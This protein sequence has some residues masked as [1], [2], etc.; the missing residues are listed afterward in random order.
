MK[1][2]VICPDGGADW[3]VSEL[4][5]KTPMEAG[6]L[7]NLGQLA[8]EGT[9]GRALHIPPGMDNGSDICCM[10]LLGFD[11]AKH[12]TGR[13]PLEAISLG[14]NL[15]PEDIAVRC[16]TVCIEDGIMV[17][18]TA[19]HITTA[20]SKQL[21]EEMENKFGRD[22][23]HFYP[24][25]SYRHLLVIRK[26]EGIQ[27]KWNA[28]HNITGKEVAG[29]LPSG[30]DASQLLDLMEK[31]KP[32]FAEHAVNAA[33]VKNGD[34]PASQIW[35]WG[36]GPRPSLP[37]FKDTYGVT[38][39]MISAVDLLKS[40][41]LYLGLEVLPVPGITGWI[42]TDYAAKGRWAIDA[43]EKHDFVFVHVEAPDECG[44]QGDAKNKVGAWE[45]IDSEIVGPIL[46][47]PHAKQNNL[48]ILVCPD[49][50]T[51]VQLKT[52]ATE[53]SPFVAWGPGF[54]HNGLKY[55]EAQARLSTVA[56]EKGY[57]LMGRFLRG[58]LS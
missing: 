30:P 24:G 22:G 55:T 32:V 42:D 8:S 44:H 48:R 52:H 17:D 53:P 11:P 46:N 5:N 23:L 7:P 54:K 4:G 58:E 51:P 39:A 10:S 45:K 35:L 41:A 21:I 26:G 50:P 40:L 36:H 47:S 6:H 20:E 33:R 56:V 34:S 49:H 29:Y 14:V 31:S 43:L 27:A 3:P 1:Y 12:H 57:E 9:V 19:G 16:N 13:A 18:F 25:T 37:P 2:V 38:G 28:P 15:G